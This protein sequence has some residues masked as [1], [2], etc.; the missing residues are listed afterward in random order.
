MMKNGDGIPVDKEEAMRYFEM[1]IAKKYGGCIP[2]YEEL[3]RELNGLPPKHDKTKPKQ[4]S[5]KTEER[6]KRES[7]LYLAIPDG[8]KNKFHVKKRDAVIEYIKK[9]PDVSFSKVAQWVTD[10]KSGA[11]TVKELQD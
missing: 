3:K 1:E 10:I 6:D 7:Y 9:H 8:Y 4:K 2:Q 5:E 11:F